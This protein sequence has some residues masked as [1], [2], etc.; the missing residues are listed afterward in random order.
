MPS[1]C[2]VN[3][4]FTRSSSKSPGLMTGIGLADIA[5]CM[6]DADCRNSR[7]VAKGL[8]IRLVN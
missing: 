5:P 3:S 7:E 4:A 2:R 8:S 6:R 1:R